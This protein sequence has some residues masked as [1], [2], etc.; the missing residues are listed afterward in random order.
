M[1][2]QKI[3]AVGQSRRQG[4]HTE[5]VSK[6]KVMDYR[7]PVYPKDTA[8]MGKLFAILRTDERLKVLLGH[9]EEAQLNDVVN[10]FHLK[11]IP[12]GVD[13]IRQGDEGDCLYIV[14]DGFVDIFVNRPGSGLIPEDRGPKV[15][16]FGPGA[17]F[18]EL[19]LMYKTPRAATVTAVTLVRT[20][21]LDAVD[22]RFLLMQ[23]TQEKFL[24]Y[25]GWLR[26]VELLKVLNH[27]E[28][29]Q[30]SEMMDS[31]CFDADEEVIT[32]GEVGD[33]FYILE[34]GTA[35]AYICGPGGE[36]MVKAYENQGEYFGEVALLTDQPRKATVR[37]TGQGCSV[38]S[39]SKDKFSQVLGPIG[40]ILKK[41]VDLYPQY[42]DFLQ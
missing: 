33:R 9:L 24:M 31:H 22:F 34:D 10:A 41:H 18:G 11:D 13:V 36:K 17:L 6:E 4:I 28:L 7:K 12:Q 15:A 20:F 26:E 19:A 40:E 5:S 39:I 2:A 35:A 25:E 23:T 29:S 1:E 8:Q 27:Y 37:A 32:Q 42:A 16:S 14:D 21:V 38:A 30:L 3:R